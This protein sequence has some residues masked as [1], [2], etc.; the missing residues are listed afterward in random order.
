MKDEAVSPIRENQKHY[1][2]QFAVYRELYRH[3]QDL[4]HLKG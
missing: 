3:N 4:F 2:E 1:E